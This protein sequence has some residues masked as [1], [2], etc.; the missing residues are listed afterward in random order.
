MNNYTSSGISVASLNQQSRIQRDTQ[1]KKS[2][3]NNNIWRDE[4]IKSFL[5][6]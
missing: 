6:R 4:R 3:N 2:S 5:L 1:L